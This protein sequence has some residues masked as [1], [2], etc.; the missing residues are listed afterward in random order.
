MRLV[1]AEVLL[2]EGMTKA[3]V[4]IADGMI[5]PDSPGREVDLAG[6]LVLPGMVDLHGDGF[7]RHVAPR[8]GVMRDLG[9]G[10]MSV[11]AEL[12]ANGITTATLAQFFSWEGGMRGRDFAER[13]CTALSGSRPD[14]LTD[15]RLQLRFETH[16]LD[17]YDRF[18]ALVVSSG[19]S[20]V[21]FND[22]LPHDALARGK[23]PPRLTGQ[24]LKS[25]RSPD[26]HLALLQE[27]HARS[28]EVPGAIAALATRLL[29]RGVLLGSHDDRTQEDRQVWRERGV[30]VSEFPETHEAALAAAQAGDPVILGAPNVV[31]GGSHSGNVSAAELIAG[32][33]GDALASDYHYP[34]L[35][36]AVFRLVA[37]GVM[38]LDAAWRMVSEGPAQVLGL[39]DR[40]RIEPG[41]RADLVVM[42]R[43][44]GLIGATICRGRVSYMSGEVAD[45]FLATW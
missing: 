14:L 35:R 27:M 30:I 32:G 21:V 23:R 44:T 13:F 15:M 11:D 7:E 16:L 18:E 22:H 40:G 17:D 5:Q 8:R 37:D 41:L 43:K 6:F 19:A 4:T 10:L 12:A 24:A 33:I 2:P 38:E 45:R 34:A 36:Q 3:T 25:G 28:P 9:Q 31:R 20:A 1:G 39:Q 29:A 42:H 26:A